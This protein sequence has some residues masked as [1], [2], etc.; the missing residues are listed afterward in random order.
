MNK[1][2][3]NLHILNSER[4]AALYLAILVLTVL[5]TVAF[6]IG[7]VLFRQVEL[8]GGIGDSVA[9]FYA[10]ETG[11]EKILY[12]DKQGIN[13]VTDCAGPTGCTG[14]LANSATYKVIVSPG[15]GGC[16]G[17]FYCADTEGTFEQATRAISIER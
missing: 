8:L 11:L 13:I 16:A 3:R 12:D 7:A 1:L 17:F 2:W 6:G 15:G 5:M 4:G 9:A 14:S 10:A